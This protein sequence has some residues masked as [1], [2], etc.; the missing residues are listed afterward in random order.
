MLQVLHHDTF[1]ISIS[2]NTF[3]KECNAYTKDT[4]AIFDPTQ[5]IPHV[6]L[7]HGDGHVFTN[8]VD[9]DV[10]LFLGYLHS[11]FVRFSYLHI[12]LENAVER[13]YNRAVFHSKM[14]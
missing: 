12:P 13:I 3:L 9:D 5:M 11:V 2:S 8:Y 6:L 10:D 1:F 7:R 4:R 14:F